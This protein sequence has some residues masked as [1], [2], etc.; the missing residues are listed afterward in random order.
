MACTLIYETVL[1]SVDPTPWPQSNPKTVANLDQILHSLLCQEAALKQRLD[2][3]II[4]DTHRTLGRQLSITPE[5]SGCFHCGRGEAVC[6]ASRQGDL[7]P[8]VETS[9]NLMTLCPSHYD[10]SES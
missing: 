4:S 2:I 6:I 7:L 3:A 10:D 1:W 9:H 8:Q 5:S